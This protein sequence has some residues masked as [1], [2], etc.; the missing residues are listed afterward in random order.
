[1]NADCGGQ[2]PNSGDQ[3]AQSPSP[4]DS[5]T[6]GKPARK[7]LGVLWGRFD[8]ILDGFN[9]INT[10]IAGV[11]GLAITFGIIGVASVNQQQNSPGKASASTSP[12]AFPTAMVTSPA[13]PG[14]SPSAAQTPTP[15]STP[16]FDANN[17]IKCPGMDIYSGKGVSFSAGCGQQQ[18]S[19]SADLR[20]LRS[21]I[22]AGSGGQLVESY[23]PSSGGPISFFYSCIHPSATPLTKFDTETAEA[24]SS[25]CYLGRHYRVFAKYVKHVNGYVNLSS[26]YI[27]RST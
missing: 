27:W 23:P 9:K 21:Q 24:E 5:S 16:S 25:F 1:M 7:R 15:A 18:V 3:A 19:G 4:S 2:P 26:V 11:I 20:Y 17:Y 6:K 13:V 12:S 10:A 14:G 22:L 8:K